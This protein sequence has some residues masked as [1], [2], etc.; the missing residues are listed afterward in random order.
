MVCANQYAVHVMRKSH[1]TED[2][3]YVLWRKDTRFQAQVLVTKDE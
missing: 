3:L 2:Q 1:T